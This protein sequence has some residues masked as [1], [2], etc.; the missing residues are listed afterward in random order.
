M[1]HVV[2]RRIWLSGS[3][4]L[5]IF[6]G[7]MVSCQGCIESVLDFSLVDLHTGMY[8]IMLLVTSKH[9]CLGYG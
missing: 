8:T 3:V 9:R 6:I 5:T 7:K 1:S 4:L 2:A